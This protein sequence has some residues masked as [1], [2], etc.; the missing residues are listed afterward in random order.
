MAANAK[1]LAGR[2]DRPFQKF[3]HCG[4]DMEAQPLVFSQQLLA[5]RTLFPELLK[6]LSRYSVPLEKV[7]KLAALGVAQSLAMMR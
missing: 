5:L 2:R 6:R 7:I 3:E 1:L 4:L